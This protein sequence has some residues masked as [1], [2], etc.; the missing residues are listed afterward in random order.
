MANE[1]LAAH[2]VSLVELDGPAQTGLKWVDLFVQLVSIERH[3]GFQAERVARAEAAGLGA[4]LTQFLPHLSALL[5]I[6]NELEAIFPRVASPTEDAGLATV[7][8][9]AGVVVG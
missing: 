4:A 6:D 5:S 7:G 3:G 1:R 2:K 8:R 9:A